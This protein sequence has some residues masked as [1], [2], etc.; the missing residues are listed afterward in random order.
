MTPHTRSITPLIV[1]LAA[2]LAIPCAAQAQNRRKLDRA[3]LKALESGTT[4][5]QSVIIRA[6]VG[7]LAALKNTLTAHGHGDTIEV[8]HPSIGALSA[9]VDIAD[10][11][12]LAA[13]PAVLSVSSNAAVKGFANPNTGSG[14]SAASVLRM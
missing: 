5:A 4:S 14:S 7:Q 3:L 8:E 10:L 9:R 13:N 1:L 6:Q 11:D 2:V 12:A